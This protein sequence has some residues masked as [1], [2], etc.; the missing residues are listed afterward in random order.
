M[1]NKILLAADG[2]EHSKR[3]ADHAFHIAACSPDSTVVIV[4]V[5]N[6]S[7]AKSDVLSNWNSPDVLGVRKERV[8]EIETIAKN[9]GVTYVLE[10]LHGEPGPTIVDYANKQGFDVLVIGSRGLNG[11][12]E[13]VLGSVSHKVAK[14]ANCPVLIVK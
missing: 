6:S 3:A 9:A 13:F 4:Y 12:Q 7:R 2:S 5:I 14:R 10:M 1:Y 8:K 11:L